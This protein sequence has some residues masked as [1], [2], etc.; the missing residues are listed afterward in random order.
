[1]K[2]MIMPCVL[3]LVLVAALISS[4][5]AP[6]PELISREVL[7]AWGS[8]EN[9]YSVEHSSV[10]RLSDEGELLWG[11]SGVRLDDWN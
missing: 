7:F 9:V 2:K 10:Q 11:D 4:C 6:E 3:V 8:S 5:V 1:M